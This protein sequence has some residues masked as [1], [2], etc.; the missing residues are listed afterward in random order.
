M[1]QARERDRADNKKIK[2]W[3]PTFLDAKIYLKHG[4]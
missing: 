2:I 4:L 1:F 3:L